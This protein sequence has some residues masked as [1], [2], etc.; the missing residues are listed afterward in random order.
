[1]LVKSGEHSILLSKAQL[2]GIFCIVCSAMNKMF[3]THLVVSVVI[4]ADVYRTQHSHRDAPGQFFVQ[5]KSFLF[6][7]FSNVVK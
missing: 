3:L 6:A 5:T 7:L 4:A 2:A 1:M